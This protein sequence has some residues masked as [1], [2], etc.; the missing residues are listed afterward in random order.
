[1]IA[2]SPPLDSMLSRGDGVSSSIV[3]PGGSLQWFSSQCHGY[4]LA[5]KATPGSRGLFY[6]MVRDGALPGRQ[7]WW[8][9]PA[10][11]ETEAAV[12]VHI[13]LFCFIRF[14]APDPGMG[15]P[16]SGRVEISQLSSLE[17][18]TTKGVVH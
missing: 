5:N 6:L 1:M 3:F 8:Q 16:Y 15:C 12:L 13:L 9:D 2:D 18:A 14:R 7:T 10:G 17:I 11:Q 4:I